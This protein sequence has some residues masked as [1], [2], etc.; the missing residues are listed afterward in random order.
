MKVVHSRYVLIVAGF[1]MGSGFILAAIGKSWLTISLPL[2]VFTGMSP[3]YIDL[4]NYLMHLHT[5]HMLNQ[6]T[7][8]LVR[9]I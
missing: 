3:F 2:I 6:N 1:M 5:L 7:R 8:L 4:P 9:K